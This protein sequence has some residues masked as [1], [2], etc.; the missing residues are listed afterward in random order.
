MAKIKKK[1][2]LKRKDDAAFISVKQAIVRLKWTAE[3]DLDLM[4]FYRAM[5]GRTG[6]VFSGKYPGGD[7]GSL[8][9]FPYIELS[10]D[11][12]VGAIGGDNEEILRIAQL[13]ELAE[14]YIVTL[15][16]TDAAEGRESTF[17]EYNG[18]ITVINDR[19]EGIEIPLESNERGHVAVICRIDS[20]NQAR[21]RLVNM[22]SVVSLGV[23]ASKVPGAHL[24][25]D[26]E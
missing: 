18:S 6:G 19:G 10:D 13:S 9:S 14:L 26:D 21:A 25:V 3:V 22:N 1:V 4:A 24:I 20:T 11:E 2:M 15:N 17:G 23:F 7:M 8:Q 5:D 16:Y 12:G